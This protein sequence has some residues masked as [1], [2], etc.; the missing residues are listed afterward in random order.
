MFSGDNQNKVDI[1][2]CFVLLFSIVSCMSAVEA[3]QVGLAVLPASSSM[4]M[5][6]YRG[7]T[8]LLKKDICLK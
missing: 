4:H 8:A 5:L 2:K 7:Q 6:A 3:K 1:C